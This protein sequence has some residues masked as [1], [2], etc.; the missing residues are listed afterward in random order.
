LV[1]VSPRLLEW[2]EGDAV[3]LAI[4]MKISPELRAGEEAT[5]RFMAIVW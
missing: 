5:S 1:F 3:I 2:L 4:S